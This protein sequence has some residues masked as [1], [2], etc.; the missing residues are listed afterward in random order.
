M[1]TIKILFLLIFFSILTLSIQAQVYCT[2]TVYCKIWHIISI[3]DTTST[4]DDTT[5]TNSLSLDS[6]KFLNPADSVKFLNTL[7]YCNNYKEFNFNSDEEFNLEIEQAKQQRWEPYKVILLYSASIMMNA[8]GDGLND[9][10]HNIQGH[11][12]NAASVGTLLLSPAIMNYQR[13]KW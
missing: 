4:T 12:W 6:V 10:Q 13:D 2:D 3:T 11:I 7:K 5:S 8:I 9:S 1:K